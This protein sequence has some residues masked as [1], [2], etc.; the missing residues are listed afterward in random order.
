MRFH[1][2]EICTIH[3]PR[4]IEYGKEMFV[5]KDASR[6]IW[7]WYNYGREKTPDNLNRLDY[8][9]LDAL[10]VSLIATGNSAIDPKVSAFAIMGQPAFQFI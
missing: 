8:R 2:G 3:D 7:E 1:E 5:I 6:V 10:N 4:G 9:K